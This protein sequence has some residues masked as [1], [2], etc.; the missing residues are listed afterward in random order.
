MQLEKVCKRLLIK[1]PFWGLF[2]LGLN[3]TYSNAVPTLGVRKCGIGVEL[4]VNESYCLPKKF[5]KQ[6]Q[7]KK[8]NGQAWKP[9]PTT[10]SVGDS[11]LQR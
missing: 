7:M 3:K 5:Q 10:S 9:V 2:M 1:E 4:L 6:E 11:A 8:C